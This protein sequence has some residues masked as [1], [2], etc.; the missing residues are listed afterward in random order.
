MGLVSG[1]AGIFAEPVKGQRPPKCPSSPKPLQERCRH[2][3]TLIQRTPIPIA[4]IQIALIRAL[5]RGA[6]ARTDGLRG[7]GIGIGK[8]LAGAAIRPTA[9]NM[10]PHVLEQIVRAAHVIGEEDA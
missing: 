7:F 3:G 9:G 5:L 10:P 8:G 1:V 6:G 4:H 2:Y